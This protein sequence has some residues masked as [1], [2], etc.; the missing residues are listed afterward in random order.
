MGSPLICGEPAI[1]GGGGRSLR[2]AYQWYRDADLFFDGNQLFIAR[3]RALW[4]FSKGTMMLHAATSRAGGGAGAQSDPIGLN[5]VPKLAGLDAATVRVAQAHDSFG[6][7][8]T[9]PAPGYAITPAF[10]RQVVMSEPGPQKSL[11]LFLAAHFVPLFFHPP[12]SL[13]SARSGASSF[14]ATFVDA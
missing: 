12:T 2:R 6:F 14:H 11:T 1:G 5:F 9:E 13:H 4:P 10:K 7:G 3:S 8:D